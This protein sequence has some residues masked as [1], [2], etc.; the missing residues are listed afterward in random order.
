MV[1][2]GTLFIKM[3]FFN[4]PHSVVILEPVI[5]SNILIYHIIHD[6]G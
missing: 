4:N 3:K 1:R 2:G 5:L 6:S